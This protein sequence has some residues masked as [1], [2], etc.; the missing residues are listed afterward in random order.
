MHSKVIQKWN[1]LIG[2][3]LKIHFQPEI[4]IL[5][6]F[7]NQLRD[8]LILDKIF[9]LDNLNIVLDKKYFVQADGRSICLLWTSSIVKLSKMLL[10]FIFYYTTIKQGYEMKWW[11]GNREYFGISFF[12]WGKVAYIQQ[13]FTFQ[14][15][16]LRLS[17]DSTYAVNLQKL[18]KI[19]NWK[20]TNFDREYIAI[21]NLRW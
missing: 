18:Q 2:R 12:S 4:F 10:K 17:R 5:N 14:K 6:G 20:P 3:A 7:S 16:P 13:Y 9:V 21:F 11:Q 15:G 1:F 19:D 8:F